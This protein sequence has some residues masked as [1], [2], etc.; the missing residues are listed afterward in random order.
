MSNESMNLFL[1][2]LRKNNTQDE[3]L[4]I[5]IRQNMELRADLAAA[6]EMIFLLKGVKSE[7]IN[8]KSFP[9]DDWEIITPYV[10]K[11]DENALP[12]QKYSVLKPLVSLTSEIG[13][14]TFNSGLA[15]LNRIR[16]FS[17]S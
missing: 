1:E 12:P 8:T 17:L 3:T 2:Q 14:R 7:T 15:A 6:N 10:Q 4:R 13:N 16:D 9:D 11:I 5:I